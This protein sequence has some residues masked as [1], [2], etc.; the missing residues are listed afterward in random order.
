[1]QNQ[2]LINVARDD[3][4]GSN[5]EF[6]IDCETVFKGT[7]YFPSTQHYHLKK[8][9]T[10]LKLLQLVEETNT[11]L[12]ECRLQSFFDIIKQTYTQ[13]YL[14]SH[15]NKFRGLLWK[16]EQSISGLFLTN[17]TLVQKYYSEH[18]SSLEEVAS[19]QSPDANL[20]KRIRQIS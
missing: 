17:L 10:A 19:P 14:L 9:L 4:K 16:A 15:K 1:M 3:A 2:R 6:K 12:N 5:K 13:E 18:A 11:E 8:S 20:S 7:E